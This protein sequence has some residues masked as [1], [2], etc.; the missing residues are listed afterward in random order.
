MK[1]KYN[2]L[3]LIIIIAGLFACNND[4]TCRKSRIVN[5]NVYFYKDTITKNTGDTVAKTLTLDSI[6]AYGLNN[7]SILYKKSTK[8]TYVQFPLNQFATLSRFVM[9][10]NTVYDT[11][12]VYYTNNTEFLSLECGN[13]YV[14]RIDSVAITGHFFDYATVKNS[15]VNTT[16]TSSNASNI[17]IHH[18]IK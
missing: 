3:L 13:V 18:F 9:K 6:T 15:E 17:E 5:L 11:L 12:T 7:D 10:C 1:K 2:I 8:K 4:E 16:S 14:Q